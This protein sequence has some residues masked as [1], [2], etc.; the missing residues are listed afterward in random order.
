MKLTPSV[1]CVGLQIPPAALQGDEHWDWLLYDDPQPACATLNVAA[2]A[3]TNWMRT[4]ILTEKRSGV[5][6]DQT[7]VVDFVQVN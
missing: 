4:F 7:G 3:S 1:L 6:N 2:R 5:V